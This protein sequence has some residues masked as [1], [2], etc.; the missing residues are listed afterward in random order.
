MALLPLTIDLHLGLTTRYVKRVSI[1]RTLMW[2]SVLSHLLQ[3]P[4]I[5]LT[6]V[7]CEHQLILSIVSQCSAD[8]YYK[9]YSYC[10]QC[11]DTGLVTF[12]T[13]QGPTTPS[14][15]YQSYACSNCWDGYNVSSN[16]SFINN[17]GYMNSPCKVLNI[18]LQRHFQHVQRHELQELPYK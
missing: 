6:A 9:M 3:P 8:I 12:T 2:C 15:T 11:S 17:T 10:Q 13:G 5:S 1:M 4:L 7:I 18:T 14:G 16:T